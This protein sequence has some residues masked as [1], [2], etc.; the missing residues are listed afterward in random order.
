M[1]KSL[2]YKRCDNCFFSVWMMNP[3]RPVLICMQKVNFVGRWRGVLIDSSCGNFYPSDVCKQGSKAIRRIPLTR[4]KF[5]LVDAEDYY[6]LSKFNWFATFSGKTFYAGRKLAGGTINMHRVIMAAPEGLFVD[7]IDHNGLN[8]RRSN[9]RLCT[10]K[11][12]NCNTLPR[13][14][15]SSKYKGVSYSKD[16]KRFRV[17]IQHN[18][19]SYFLGYFKDEI[20]AA[21]AYDKAAKKYFGEYAYLNFPNK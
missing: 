14:G 12:N 17:C 4:G 8:N 18:K 10:Y 21:K 15:C 5:A 7:H 16:K 20:A 2:G 11:Q 19:K 3:G 13:K 9:L 1:G 6:R